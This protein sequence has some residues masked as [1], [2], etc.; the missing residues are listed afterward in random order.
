MSR[1]W[2]VSVAVKLIRGYQLIS[3]LWPRVCRFHPTC[4]QFAK[5]ALERHGFFRGLW[6]SMARISRCHPFHPGGI[7][8]VP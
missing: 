3:R 8:P 4:S 1:S 5:E 2:A 6:L 7:D